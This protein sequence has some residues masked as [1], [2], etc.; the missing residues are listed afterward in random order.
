MSFGWSA[1]D[2]ANLAHLAWRVVQN[3]RK[4]CGEYDELSQECFALHLVLQRLDTDFSKPGSRLCPKKNDGGDARR[5]DIL[6]NCIR[7]PE[8]VA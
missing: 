5:Q 4:A 6:E 7:L 1:T 2:I 8:G 3:A